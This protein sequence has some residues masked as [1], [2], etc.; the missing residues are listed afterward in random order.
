MLQLL[1]VWPFAYFTQV[2]IVLW[3]LNYRVVGVTLR[4]TKYY[5]EKNRGQIIAVK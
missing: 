2:G 5:F 4:G 3:F 1:N